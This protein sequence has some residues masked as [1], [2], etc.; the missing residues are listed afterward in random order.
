MVRR[1]FRM[2]A[3]FVAVSL[4]VLL[5]GC[6]GAEDAADAPEVASLQSKAAPAAAGTPTVAGKQRP[7]VPMDATEDDVKA[8][9]RPWIACLV[10]EGTIEKDDGS[11]WQLYYKGAEESDPGFKACMP[12]MPESVENNLKRTD[13]SAFK[14]NE[15]E[16]YQCAKLQGYKLTPPDPVTGE[17][18]LT[19]IGPNGDA[20]SPK[21][22]K[23]RREAF[24]S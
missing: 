11:M 14:D 15:R 22:E 2:R 19:A 21:M 10:K 13:L 3:K 5:G 23:C 4:L 8:L 24:A 6:A 18:G 1:M 12:L 7:I 20:H 17:F 9:T 16:F